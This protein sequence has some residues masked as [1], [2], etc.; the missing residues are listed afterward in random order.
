MGKHTIKCFRQA[1]HH[2]CIFN[3]AYAGACKCGCPPFPI[4][5]CI[6]NAKAANKYQPT[7]LVTQ[8]RLPS[9]S[10]LFPII[11]IIF[12]AQIAS[13]VDKKNGTSTKKTPQHYLDQSNIFPKSIR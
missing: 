10:M 9:I 8:M 3:M 7:L 12:F 4:H 5:A 13:E 2:M 1:T 11:S 6:V